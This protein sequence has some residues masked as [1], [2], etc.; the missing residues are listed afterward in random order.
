VPRPTQGSPEAL[1]LRGCHPLR[2]AFPDRS[3]SLPGTTG[4]LRFRS[5][6]LAESRLMS[7]PPGTEMFQF[8]GFASR[9]YAFSTGYPK[10][11]GCPIRTSADQ[12][13]LASPRGFSQRATSFIASWRQGIHRTPFSHS[14]ITAVTART[15][16]QTAPRMPNSN[17]HTHTHTTLTTFQMNLSNTTTH[18]PPNPTN[19]SRRAGGSPGSGGPRHARPRATMPSREDPPP[20]RGA[21]CTTRG[22]R[23]WRAEPAKWQRE[24]EGSRRPIGEAS[25]SAPGP[26]LERR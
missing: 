24:H 1:R 22:R 16:N 12:R 8:P 18:T 13:A 2:P 10:G 19:R 11:V 15:Q 6:L 23:E 14:P 5:P 20:Q 7:S 21:G 3:A 26:V 25:A 9:A 17:S 4:L